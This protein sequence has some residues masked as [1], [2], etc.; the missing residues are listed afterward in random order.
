M[1]NKV[2][3]CL[4]CSILRIFSTKKPRGCML[5]LSTDSSLR[6]QP[7]LS[8]FLKVQSIPRSEKYCEFLVTVR[9]VAPGADRHVRASIDIVVAID[10]SMSSRTNDPML[11][12]PNI[13]LVAAE[14]DYMKN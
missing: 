9:L 7:Q 5:S 12:L 13:N 8:T 3:A 11:E 10:V 14:P 2:A 1:C 4:S 6:T